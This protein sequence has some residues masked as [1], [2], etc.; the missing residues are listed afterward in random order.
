LWERLPNL[1]LAA[2]RFSRGHAN[3]LGLRTMPAD[4]ESLREAAAA[5]LSATPVCC[6]SVSQSMFVLLMARR[7]RRSI[8]HVRRRSNRHLSTERL[9]GPL[10]P[11][12]RRGA[13]LA[14]RLCS[15][16][17]G[18]I[19]AGTRV[20]VVEQR[21]M[22]DSAHRVC[23]VL[24]GRRRPLGWLTSKLASGVLALRL[25]SDDGG[26]PCLDEPFALLMPW[27]ADG[28]GMAGVVGGTCGSMERHLAALELVCISRDLARNDASRSPPASRTSS[29]LGSARSPDASLSLGSARSALGS[30][31]PPLGSARSTTIWLTQCTL[32]I[33]A[34]GV[35]A[36]LTVAA[37]CVRAALCLLHCACCIVCAWRQVG[38]V[39]RLSSL[40]GQR[41]VRLA[42][43]PRDARLRQLVGGRM[44]LARSLNESPHRQ[45]QHR[46][47]FRGRRTWR[48]TLNAAQPLLH[49]HRRQRR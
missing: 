39:S 30:A 10:A 15:E 23:V 12:T 19:P 27:R 8:E 31:R 37:L 33:D 9:A 5:S 47:Q 43:T 20:H 28:L 4:R 6:A 18:T 41:R 2:E 25:A 35:C 16:E 34:R 21:R 29:P 45:E 1:L 26:A 22:A 3:R 46:A 49:I 40:V 14:R 11:L 42:H 36:A 24:V 32:R 7:V 48:R 44:G 13:R 17:V 38:E